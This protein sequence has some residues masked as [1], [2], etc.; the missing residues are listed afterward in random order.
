MWY[1]SNVELLFSIFT[2]KIYNILNYKPT[3]NGLVRLVGT[4]D[5]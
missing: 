4:I 5:T 3:N 2:V 1:Y